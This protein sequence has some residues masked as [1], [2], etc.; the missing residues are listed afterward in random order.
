MM[1]AE[2][3]ERGARGLKYCQTHKRPHIRAAGLKIVTEIS[4][5]YL[6]NAEA[7]AAC[8]KIMPMAP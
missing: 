8:S 7:T 2:T 6:M 1:A 5:S 4:G 3:S